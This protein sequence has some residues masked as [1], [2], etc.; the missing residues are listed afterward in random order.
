MTIYVPRDPT[1]EVLQWER[2]VRRQW[3]REHQRERRV[4]GTSAG[5]SMRQKRY[6]GGGQVQWVPGSQIIWGGGGGGG[7]GEE[8]DYIGREVKKNNS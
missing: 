5:L 6:Q 7:G 4:A 2:E 1:G 3:D 8:D